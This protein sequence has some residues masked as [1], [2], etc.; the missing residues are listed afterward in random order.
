MTTMTSARTPWFNHE[1]DEISFGVVLSP[2]A[3]FFM[4]MTINV[5]EARP[6]HA[7][8]LARDAAALEF[9]G[10]QEDCVGPV[11]TVWPVRRSLPMDE[12]RRPIDDKLHDGSGMY[13]SYR[14]DRSL[15]PALTE[16]LPFSPPVI[17]DHADRNL[18]AEAKRTRRP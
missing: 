4:T 9:G 13:C 14:A 2:A 10:V 11:P 12:Y 17:S 6:P 8:Y 3:Q 18:A 7:A 1:A 15:S 16:R 5:S